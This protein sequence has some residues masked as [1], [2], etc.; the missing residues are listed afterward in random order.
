M[1]LGLSP[2][3]RGTTR[4]GTSIVYYHDQ[5]CICFG[6]MAIIGLDKRRDRYILGGSSTY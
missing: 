5:S 1:F 3:G 4:G 2:A 6:S